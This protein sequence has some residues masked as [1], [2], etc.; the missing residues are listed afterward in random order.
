MAGL[1]GGGGG[2]VTVQKA[3]APPDQAEAARLKD[4]TTQLRAARASTVLTSD[5]G[6][7]NLGSTASPSA[8][9]GGGQ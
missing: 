4:T 6:L 5:T 9:N 8:T 7:P 1:F 3:P 2:G